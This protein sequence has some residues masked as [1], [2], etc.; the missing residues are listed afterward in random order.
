MPQ[1]Q[2]NETITAILAGTN[3]TVSV[4]PLHSALEPL[5]LQDGA[6]Q[7]P[8]QMGIQQA[9]DYA[10]VAQAND[11]EA[12]RVHL[13]YPKILSEIMTKGGIDNLL[14][15]FSNKGTKSKESVKVRLR[16]N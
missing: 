7:A 3:V 13:S 11:G 14:A 1:G 15:N 9:A 12:G 2:N 8:L 4:A 6:H 10:Q 5:Q 16:L